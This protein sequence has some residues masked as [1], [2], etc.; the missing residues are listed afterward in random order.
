MVQLAIPAWPKWILTGLTALALV[1]GLGDSLSLNMTSVAVAQDE[2]PEENAPVED[3]AEPAPV[4]ADDNAPAAVG[5]QA[6]E[7]ETSY[8]TWVFEALGVGYMLIF[9]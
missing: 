6:A 9:L 1:V 5:D 3:V 4:D 2:L 8:L 7:G